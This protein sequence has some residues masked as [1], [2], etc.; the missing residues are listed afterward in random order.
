MSLIGPS[1]E[2]MLNGSITP[3][4]GGCSCSC[5]RHPGVKHVMACCHP[6]DEE[7]WLKTN[8]SLLEMDLDIHSEEKDDVIIT[9]PDKLPTP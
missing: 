2:D 4:Y 3:G 6:T 5:H 8:P 7:S 1:I 9:A